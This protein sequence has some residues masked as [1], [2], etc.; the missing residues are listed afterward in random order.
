MTTPLATHILALQ[1]A[2]KQATAGQWEVISGT[3][4]GEFPAIGV[5]GSS[6][7]CI[8]FEADDIAQKKADAHAIATLRN[9][10]ATTAAILDVAVRALRESTYL[11]HGSMVREA[12][13][14]ALDEMNR[15]A[16]EKETK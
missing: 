5:K 2:D 6:L 8:G 10:A 3:Y 16:G 14:A 9:S 11:P 1:N 13:E 15:L 12:Q 4:L 7:T